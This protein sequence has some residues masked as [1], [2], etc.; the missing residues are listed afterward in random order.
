MGMPV[1]RQKKRVRTLNPFGFEEFDDQNDILFFI[2]ITIANRSVH[3]KSLFVDPFRKF[4][5]FAPGY[6]TCSQ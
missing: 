5:P 4:H 6:G 2:L 1:S 3:K